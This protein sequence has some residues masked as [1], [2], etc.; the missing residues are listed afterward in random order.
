VVRARD[1]MC[2]G[3]ACPVFSSSLLP[4]SLRWSPSPKRRLLMKILFLY[5]GENGEGGRED[6]D[7]GRPKPLGLRI[8]SSSSSSSDE[9]DA[10]T[11]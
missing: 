7:T 10:C 5:E 3:V 11:L 1:G 2:D 4:L 9:S 8:S 6:I